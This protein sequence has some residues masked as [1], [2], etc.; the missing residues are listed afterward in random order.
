MLRNII[1]RVQ[2]DDLCSFSALVDSLVAN[3]VMNDEGQRGPLRLPPYVRVPILALQLV[4]GEGG[5]NF[6]VERI[7]AHFP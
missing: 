7:M 3:R 6:R 5:W 4:A 2:E 1:G